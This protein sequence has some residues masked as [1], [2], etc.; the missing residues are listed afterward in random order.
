VGN[1]GWQK[2]GQIRI[3]HIVTYIYYMK[4]LYLTLSFIFCLQVL[5]FSQGDSTRLGSI[6]SK[7][8]KQTTTRPIEK[9]YL[10]FNKPGY[11]V[12]D[13]I[14]FKGYL[15][16]G[17]HH[18]LSAL[19][20]ILYVE[21][22][23]GRDKVIKSLR[24]KVVDGVAVGEI[25]I[26]STL[27]TGD[28]RI[29]AY[30]NWMRNSAPD[31]FFN[32]T[33]NI[34]DIKT[35][36]VF[37]A[38]AFDVS[39]KNKEGL[40]NAKLAYTDKFGRA[41]DHKQVTYE[42]KADTVALFK[43][44]GITDDK[45][46][47]T[48]AFSDKAMAGQK[49]LS[50]VTHFK[51]LAGVVVDKTIPINLQNEN[52]D[53][54]FFPEG[55]Q[56]VNGVRSKIAFKAIGINGLSVAVSGSV[57]DNNHNE[58]AEFNTQHAGMGIFA[59]TPEAGK[60]YIAKV[61]M[62]DSSVISVNLPAAA[63][64]GFVLT[65]NS[66]DSLV[67]K[68]HIATNDVTLQGQQNASFYLVGQ[69]GGAAYYTTLGK[70]D[71]PNFT[72]VVAKS[73]FPTGIVQ[74]TL[75]SAAMEPLNER[76]VFIQNL[77][78][79]SLNLTSDK[80]VYAAKEKVKMAF[81][82]KDFTGKLSPGSFSLAV[83]NDDKL[84][85]NENAESTILSNILLTSDL[86]GYIEGP[87]YYFNNI[88]DESK[89]D[90]DILML[91][92]G[93]R[94]FDW[95]E[96]MADSYPP[97][98]FQPERSLAIAGMLT[99]SSGKPVA[100][101]RVS[102][103]SPLDVVHIDTVTD[104]EGK[105]NF[106][107]IE[108]PDSTKLVIQAR[109]ANDGKNVEISLDNGRAVPAIYKSNIGDAAQSLEAPVFGRI[110]TNSM[111]TG[112]ADTAQVAAMIKE[113]TINKG[114]ALKEVT[115]KA[116][117]PD[118]P[119]QSNA[120]G[121]I[122][123]DAV[124]SGETLKDY[125]TITAAIM[126]KTSGLVYNDRR[127]YDPDPFKA[128][129]P[130]PVVINGFGVQ[131]SDNIDDIIG[132]DVIEDIKLLQ[133]KGIL[134][135]YGF[136]NNSNDRII[137]ITTK[138]FAGTDT[139]KMELVKNKNFAFN[140]NNKL[141]DVTVKANKIGK[142]A[143][144]NLWGSTKPLAVISGETL[145]GYAT[146]TAGIT[147]KTLANYYKDGKI[148]DPIVLERCRLT[149]VTPTPIPVVINESPI[150]ID[151]NIDDIIGVDVI[152]D[153]K[154]LQGKGV[155]DNYGFANNPNDKLILITTKQFAGTD[156][157]KMALVK[158]NPLNRNLKEVNIKGRKNAGTENAPWKAV[159]T[160]S[161]NLNGPGN[162]DQ[163][164][165]GQ[166]V[167][168]CLTLGDCL[169]AKIPGIILKGGNYYFAIHIAQ[170]ITTPPPIIFIIDGQLFSGS[171]SVDMLNNVVVANIA[172]IEVL[173]SS[174]YLNIYGSNASGGALVIT[175][176]IGNEGNDVYASKSA[177]GVIY[178]RFNGFY[179]AKQFYLPK[180]NY[181]GATTQSDT[182]T[183]IYWNPYITTDNTGAIPIEFYNS[184]IKGVYRAVVE[185]IDN[186]GN[187]GRCVYRY[188]VE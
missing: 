100:S 77:D 3:Y 170:S 147:A 120:W 126:V 95:K 180:Y 187:I 145:K 134:A 6:V 30:T 93:Y 20:G 110:G 178:T 105:F 168:G 117:T 2:K 65:I 139:T 177:P 73:K 183:A 84:T 143:Q 96:V 171:G 124:I 159:V 131:P 87:N 162:A 44:M 26:G 76:V 115:I 141:K 63:D 56:L 164:L 116:K 157:S 113:N 165:T 28:Y 176:K 122:R 61:T 123:P 185:G 38:S 140:S 33:I 156:T 154:L 24:L 107:A 82:T 58:V 151:D 43:G 74:F 169:Q 114:K 150:S 89:A 21:M 52:T 17:P 92:Q 166:D 109:K 86:K 40:V 70:L 149:G 42:V 158:N 12:G 186:D 29:R 83:F 172:T 46:N 148:Y 35:S 37:V 118:K 91:T 67:L 128:K 184:D 14:W 62:P 54:Q 129:T 25:A 133:G 4:N 111:V 51:L 27:P 60:T 136:V 1:D 112:T 18:Q 188:R 127:I 132:V 108:F 81:T 15:T 9:V 106:P 137:L 59:L 36:A 102:V 88:T 85:G 181:T 8:D 7:L 72:A 49:R 135:T 78:Q 101:G 80:P 125:A 5:A 90:L 64:R 68:I 45:G 142:S 94:R 155:L 47:L 98:S 11:L 10:H 22:I 23:D 79:L 31:Y 75:F 144:S 19:S 53:V 175:T 121:T 179:K 153:I 173:K 163:V 104:A 32:K 57:F 55:G 66:S 97:I 34:G 103:F 146:I 99:T 41:Y 16:V 160:T 138:Q 39:G 174:S 71:N 48:F 152:E 119:D 130:I 50:I 13:T 161:A 167:D 69:S 182:R